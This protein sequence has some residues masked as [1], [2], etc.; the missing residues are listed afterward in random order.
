[1]GKWVEIRA[2]SDSFPIAL[3]A[4]PVK[5][6]STWTLEPEHA[7]NI[8]GGQVTAILLSAAALQCAA[9]SLVSIPT[10][11]KER[12]RGWIEHCFLASYSPI[13]VCTCHTI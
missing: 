13:L 6:Q 3:M 1:M 12:P 4:L 9:L 10:M 8:R 7:L 5:P 11:C 2:R